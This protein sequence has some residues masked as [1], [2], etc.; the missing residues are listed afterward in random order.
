MIRYF[1]GHPTIANLLMLLFFA[2][3]LAATPSMQR[4]TFPR[5]DGRKVQISIAYPGAR[6]E[7]IEEAVCR[8]IEDA[9]ASIDNV[10]EVQCEARENLALSVVEMVE[11]NNL[12]RFF[13]DV[14]AEVEAIEDFPDKTEAPILNILGRTDFVA[15]IALTGTSDPSQLKAYAE[16]LKARMLASGGIPKVDIEG[17]SEH[18]IRI[19]LADTVLRQYGLSLDGIAGLISRQSLDLPAGSIETRDG[20]VLV[21]VAEE[22]KRLHEFLDLI[23][24]SGTAGGQVR[25]GDIATISD[26]F[27]LDEEKTL[28]NGKRAAILKITK[29]QNEDTLNVIDTVRKF[30]EQ[31]NKTAPPS[32]RLDIT[33]DGSS[34]V[35]DRLQL[36]LNN[37]LLGL[38]LVFLVMLLFFGFNYAFWITMGLPVS[39]MGAFAIMVGLGYS[40]NMFTMVAL[41]MVIGLLMDD[42]IV[43]SENIA[44]HSEKGAD[45]VDAAVKGTLQVMPGI[46]SSFGTTACIFGSLAFL[47]GDIG[48][49]LKIVPVVMLAVLIISLVEAFLI[50]P[51]HLGHALSKSNDEKSFLMRNTDRFVDWMRERVV[52]RFVDITVAWRYLTTGIAIAM[53]LLAIT[54]MAGGILKFTPFPNLEG[55]TIE[56]RLLLPQGTPLARTEATI[57]QLTNALRGMDGELR[58]NEPNQQSLLRNVTVLFN[59]NKDAFEQG[60]HLATIR[61]DLV[62]SETRH[63]RNDAILS[64]WRKNAGLLTDV[65][66][67]KF[68]EPTDGPGGK[69]IEIRLLGRDLQAL[70]SA[71]LDL[72]S[73]LRRY[74]GVDDIADDLRPGKPEFAVRLRES[75]TSLGLDSKIIADQLRSA[76]F[77]RSISNIQ[78]EAESYEV[79]V[80]LRPQDKNSLADLDYF[81]I[82]TGAG[83][84]IP[85]SSIADIERARGYSRINRING[86][87]TVTISGE[88]DS[89]TT[90]TNE[91]LSDMQKRFIPQFLKRHPAV[92]ISLEGENKE[93]GKTQKSMIIG[94]AMGLAGVFLLL[95][96][97]FRSYI[98][99]LVVMIVIPFAFIGAVGGHIFMGID[100]TMPS[101]LGFVALAGVVVNDS[102]LLINFIKDSHGPDTTVAQAAPIAARARFRAILL[103]SLTTI[104][105][106]LPMLTETSLQAQILIPLVTSLAFGLIASTILVLFVVPAIYAILDDFGLSALA[107]ERHAARTDEAH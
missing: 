52:G 80:R 55:N 14:T 103:T 51:N 39:I 95:S 69:A 97:Q 37:G 77:G 43:I 83:D 31:E 46:L 63:S 30:I 41:L 61:V 82:S 71:S 99:P 16:D 29:T 105:G 70:K 6:A 44:A 48:A 33:N 2:I 56:A 65:L 50:L 102:I 34:I 60:K 32:V 67:L 42:A 21:R 73:W 58:K 94:F 47:K 45:P 79:N 27:D 85:L 76:L 40:L 86:A 92:K 89:L 96:F 66:T 53:L 101:M 106:L 57:L 78:L 28:F 38:L 90:N 35:R 18:Q 12:D 93:T 19:E 84:Q 98:E 7:D 26:R 9:V 87:R 49:I 3:G 107:R 15:D 36:L 72:Q 81:T 25:L 1:A 59:Q 17:F 24:I 75:A 8:R 22:R 62:D 20:E 88:L 64:L 74:K 91:V 23:V 104:A 11:G 68:A 4:E 10:Y 5:I 54:A 13:A 100:F